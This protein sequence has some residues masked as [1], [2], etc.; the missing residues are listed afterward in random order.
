MFLSP[1]FSKYMTTIT[2]TGQYQRI[3][4]VCRFSLWHGLAA[5]STEFRS[6]RQL[7]AAFFTMVH[8]VLLVQFWRMGGITHFDI[9]ISFPLVAPYLKYQMRLFG[10]AT[11]RYDCSVLYSHW[12]YP[13]AHY[14]LVC[15]IGFR[16]QHNKCPSDCHSKKMQLPQLSWHFSESKRL[17]T[18]CNKQT[19]C[20]Q[21]L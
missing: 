12:G 16:L 15:S 14:Q 3:C 20:F 17:S 6:R 10:I 2:L 4:V 18:R 21:Y 9:W 8:G 5:V 7:V 13:L 1:L 19:H 11:V